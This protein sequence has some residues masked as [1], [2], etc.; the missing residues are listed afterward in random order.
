MTLMCDT[1]GS[2][3]AN[4]QKENLKYLKLTNFP[5]YAITENEINGN[6]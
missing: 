2:K 4:F 3:M 5:G 6:F 1:N